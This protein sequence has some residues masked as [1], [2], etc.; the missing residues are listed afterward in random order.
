M[1]QA[2][3]QIT[4]IHKLG[5]SPT[6]QV[7]SVKWRQRLSETRYPESSETL[8]GW[9][10]S[11]RATI[12][13]PHHLD[14]KGCS[15]LSPW[16][17]LIQTGITTHANQKSTNTAQLRSLATP[18]RAL[19]LSAAFAGVYIQF[20]QQKEPTVSKTLGATAQET[21]TWGA[22]APQHQG[23]G[24]RGTRPCHSLGPA[25][26]GSAPLTC[27]IHNTQATLATWNHM[28]LF[29]WSS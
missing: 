9:L 24:A 27:F 1:R 19:L 21:C 26:P 17:L 11:P 29:I 2:L 28:R 18:R 14:Q 16:E 3:L 15:E 7:G 23:L 22:V 20:C 5:Y 4:I 12:S 13:K 8:N 25:L 10:D 6:S